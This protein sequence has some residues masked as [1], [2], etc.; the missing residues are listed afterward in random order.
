[1]PPS[2]FMQGLWMFLHITGFGAVFGAMIAGP[3]LERQFQ[4]A[5]DWQ[6]RGKIAM[7]G[8][9]I[10]V[11]ARVAMLLL[12]VSGIGNMVEYGFGFELAFS[13]QAWWLGAKIVLWAIMLING[14]LF[15]MQMM[16][17]RG[18]VMQ[19]VMAGN[20]PPDGESILK[21]TFKR[22]NMFFRIQGFMLIVV[23]ILAIFRP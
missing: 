17:I 2:S 19:K 6:V 9:R 3:M 8:M 11:I 1:M 18:S 12:L 20:I 13:C 7:M 14:Q 22:A 4:S 16:R 23:M 5:T 10:S 15:A 21:S